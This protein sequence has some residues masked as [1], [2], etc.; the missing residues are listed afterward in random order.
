[1]GARL[2]GVRRYWY[3]YVFRYRYRYV[4]LYRYLNCL[5][6]FYCLHLHFYF[7]FPLNFTDMAGELPD[8]LR[9][10]E[11]FD[12]ME[13]SLGSSN[14]MEVDDDEAA[15]ALRVRLKEYVEKRK[16][17]PGSIDSN[18][19]TNYGCG[20]YMAI[21]RMVLKRLEVPSLYGGACTTVDVIGNFRDCA[22]NSG[23]TERNLYT[24]KRNVQFSFDPATMSCLMCNDNHN[25]LGGGGEGAEQRAVFFLTN[26][27]FPQA[28]AAGTGMCS[29][30][31]RVEFGLL[32]DLVSTFLDILGGL[33]LPVGSIIVISSMTHLLVEGLDAYAG[34]M[35]DQIRRLTRSFRGGCSC[36]SGGPDIACRVEQS[37]G[38]PRCCRLL[39]LAPC[40]ECA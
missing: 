14:S 18:V 37:R 8:D 5:T 11:L 24:K 29:A 28:L 13:Q 12:K 31:V 16:S 34:T 2:I 22:N 17:A 26:Q 35:V 30:V 40:S 1:M 3:Q 36:G 9:L 32:E 6:V 21:K 7:Y 33:K 19:I 25:V 4:F 27:C 23:L 39:P 15:E 10:G 20:T 38:R